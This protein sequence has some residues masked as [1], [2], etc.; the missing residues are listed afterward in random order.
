MNRVVKVVS[1]A[2]AMAGGL[3]GALSS[4]Q[5]QSNYG[6]PLSLKIAN[7]I[8]PDRFFIRAGVIGVKVKTESGDTYDVT[9]PVM[10][11]DELKAIGQQSSTAIADYIAANAVY[12]NLV[13]ANAVRN[14]TPVSATDAAR[15]AGG[16]NGTTGLKS[17]SNGLNLLVQTM[18]NNGITQIGTPVG[19]KA[20]SKEEMGTA[21]I[22]L[23]YFLDDEYKW[24]VEAYVLAAP[25]KASV[26]ASGPVTDDGSGPKEF[27]I[28]GQK[29]IDAKLLPP[30]V[31]L[32]KYWG[33][34]EAKFRPYT[35]LLAMYAVFYD[36][37]ATDLLNNYV[38]GSNPGD[39]TVSIKNKFGM[40]PMLGFKYQA[41]DNWHV[42]LNVGSVKLKTEGTIVTRNTLITD[43][44]G[45]T[46]DLG[47]LTG[48]INAG[49]NAYGVNGSQGGL[50]VMTT[51]QFGGVTGLISR[52]IAQERGQNNL[53]TFVRKAN[54]TLTNT[55][56]ML[57]VGRSF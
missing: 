36:V 50:T 47:I 34:K 29:I 20:I 2:A 28:E 17:A 46:Q 5:A 31:I 27:S 12:Q 53:G 30:T 35:G 14:G 11:V 52:V 44:T 21:G 19:I 48:S 56:F 37:K 7:A 13:G 38:G 18:E 32:G 41:T 3:M 54:T 4:A 45:A 49:I 24:V 57:S 55:I 15:I 6:D 40:G 33:K 1:L 10:T 22:S 39:T 25:I 8:S 23:G 51:K 42:S 43:S 16:T 26:N 9:G